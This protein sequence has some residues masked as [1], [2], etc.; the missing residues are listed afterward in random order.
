[1]H[2]ETFIEPTQR[3][4]RY[5]IVPGASSQEGALS[6]VLFHCV[7]EHSLYIAKHWDSELTPRGPIAGT[8]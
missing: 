2:L 5:G 1:M 8:E 7:S 3:V 4:F 6:L